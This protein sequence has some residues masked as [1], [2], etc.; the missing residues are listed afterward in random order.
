MQFR[1][2]V[3]VPVDPAAQQQLLLV[4]EGRR[5][6]SVNGY[7]RETGEYSYADVAL[8]RA[9]SRPPEP[10][11][12]WWTPWPTGH[13]GCEAVALAVVDILRDG[14]STTPQRLR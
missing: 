9:A 11:R 10:V 4:L 1:S 7:D 8:W 5:A 3:P 13:D 14:F 6:K 2:V 12:Q